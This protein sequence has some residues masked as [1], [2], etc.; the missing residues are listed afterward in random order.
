[1][2]KKLICAVFGFAFLILLPLG[3][4]ASNTAITSF[5][6]DRTTVNPGQDITISITA[7]PGTS[8]VFADIDGARVH[9]TRPNNTSQNWT[10]RITPPRTMNITVVANTANNTVGAANVVIPVTVNTTTAQQPPV[11]QPSTPMSIASITETT[12]LREGEIQLTIV[13]GSAINEVWV[14]FDGTL[15]RRG[16]EQV[17]LRTATSRTWIINFRPQTLAVQTVRVGANTSYSFAGATLQDYTITLSAPFTTQRNPLIQNVSVQN[18]DMMP[19]EQTTF[20][21]TTNTDVEFVWVVDPSGNRHNA[22]RTSAANAIPRVWTVSFA[23]QVGGNVIVHANSTNIVTGA[24]TRTEAVTV[25]NSNV[26]I[27]NATAQWV[28]GANSGSVR[29]EVRTNH[30][31][32]RVWVELDN[33]NRRPILQMTSGGTGT[34]NRVWSA[35]IPNVG[36]VTSVQVRVSE[37]ANQFNTDIS[38]NITITGVAPG[39]GVGNVQTNVVLPNNLGGWMQSAWISHNGQGTTATLT[40]NTQHAN[41]LE[42]SVN[43]PWGTLTPTRTANTSTLWTVQIPN[44][45]TVNTSQTINLTF[46]AWS[47]TAPFNSLPNVSGTI[48]NPQGQTGGGGGT[49]TG[50]VQRQIELLGNLGGWMQSAVISHSGQGTTAT[51]TITTQHANILEISVATPWGTLTPIRA[52]NTSTVW[53]VQIPNFWTV[54]TTNTVS[55]TFGAWSNAQ[56]FNQLPNV[57]GQAENPQGGTGGGTVQGTITLAGNL[58]GWMQSARINHSGQGTIA[59]LTVVTAHAN[60]LEVAV[61]TPWGVLVPTRVNNSSTEWTVQIPNFWTVNAPN[62]AS[63]TFNGWSSVSPFNSLPTVSGIWTR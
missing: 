13:T 10:L 57:H 52:N 31:A 58:G 8:F 40:I 24:V 4:Y 2:Y 43:S 50:T 19:G 32:G 14:Q 41:I 5:S 44:F 60:I 47:N 51:L 29:V 34:Q 33:G 17:A 37:N 7:S 36:N 55:F 61:S 46:S 20:T 59:T 28:Q 23:P 49:G 63:F 1:M 16:Q 9:A 21:I 45:W 3:V 27:Q 62:P 22:T 42:I 38:E 12:P 39:T 6:M 53:T 11:A 54:T 25:R 30:L 48:N 56:P 15:F 35:E 18:R 26:V